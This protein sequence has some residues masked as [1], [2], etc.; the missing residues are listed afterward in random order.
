MWLLSRL[1]FR[2]SCPNRQVS[3]V[4]GGRAGCSKVWLLYELY[5]TCKTV[6]IYG[7]L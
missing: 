1:R 7:V 5:Y 2:S 4:E 3:F 6:C